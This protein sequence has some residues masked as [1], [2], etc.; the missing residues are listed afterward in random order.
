MNNQVLV[1]SAGKLKT[2][3]GRVEGILER[4]VEG[5]FY[6]NQSNLNTP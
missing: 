5:F 1:E 6:V 4:E 2:K 3:G